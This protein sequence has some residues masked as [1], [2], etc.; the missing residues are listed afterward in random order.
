MKSPLKRPRYD[1]GPTLTLNIGF[2]QNRFKNRAKTDFLRISFF[3][4]RDFTG[5]KGYK[6]GHEQDHGSKG[7]HDKEGHKKHYEEEGGHK[8]KVF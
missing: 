6:S 3:Y 8:K 1:E 2:V 4:K 7:H 5:E